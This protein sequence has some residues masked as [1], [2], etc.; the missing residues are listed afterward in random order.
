MRPT[1]TATT[2]DATTTT[3]GSEPRRAGRTSFPHC[4][5]K[6]CDIVYPHDSAVSS[7]APNVHATNPTI[8]NASPTLPKAWAVGSPTCERL[9]TPTPSGWN[10]TAARSHQ[11]PTTGARRAGSPCTRWRG[12]VRGRTGSTS[13]RPRPTRRRTPRRA[14]SRRRTARSRSRSTSGALRR[15]ARRARRLVPEMRPV[16][17]SRTRATTTTMIAR[18]MN[19]KTVSR[20]E[21]LTRQ[22]TSHTAMPASGIQSR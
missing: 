2:I 10:T 11:R 8:R 22:I 14:S 19:P 13:P 6:Y 16:G 21:N 20:V 18:P 3:G 5:P 4:Q 1:I 15:S 12:S 17:W 7:A 9:S